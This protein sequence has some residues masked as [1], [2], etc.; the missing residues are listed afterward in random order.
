MC[1]RDRILAEQIHQWVREN[2]SKL[3]IDTS[4]KDY[5]KLY[6]IFPD[7]AKTKELYRKEGSRYTIP[8]IYN[9]N[10]FNCLINDDIYGLPNDNMGMNSKKVFLANKSKR[11]QVPYLL[12]REQVMLQAKFYDFL[13]GQASKGNLNIY[14]D[15]NRKEII[16]LKNGEKMCIRDSAG[17]VR[18]QEGRA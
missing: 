16:P 3:E 2:L 6:F 12:N 11:V 7:E 14:F 4:K 9:N 13:Y 1:I 15:E 17:A 8:N 5:L 18:G 10:D